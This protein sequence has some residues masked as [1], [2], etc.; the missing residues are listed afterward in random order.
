MII[1]NNEVINIYQVVAVVFNKG[2]D[3]RFKKYKYNNFI[4]G[5]NVN[6]V[7]FQYLPILLRVDVNS[8]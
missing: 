2:R 8:M 3:K 5:Y 4:I 1:Q 7:I 6:P